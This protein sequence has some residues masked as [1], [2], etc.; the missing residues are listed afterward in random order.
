MDRNNAHALPR[1]VAVESNFAH[2]H[3]HPELGGVVGKVDGILLDLGVSSHQIDTADRGFT[4]S[5]LD[6]PLDMRMNPGLTLRA[7]DL[8]N[9][10]DTRELASMLRTYGDESRARA[11]AESIAKH[12]PLLTTGHLHE[13]V[14]AVTPAFHK[15]SR[16]KGLTATLA[17]VFQALRIV[18]NQEDVMLE[19]A[20]TEMAP[21]LLR[22]GGRLVVLSYHS[23]EDRATKR[24][25]RDGSTRMPPALRQRDAYGNPVVALP[26][27]SM[28]KAVK[29]S[30]EEVSINSRAR[31]A[32]LRVAERLWVLV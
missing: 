6:G 14:A 2:L 27:Q 19:S 1:F 28:G 11:L 10:L 12:R 7:C 16:R 31:S 20:L 21:T 32:T 4:F 22:P 15:E 23:L 18:V 9:E 17:R 3:S 25:M 5:Q 8:C 26:F 24:V 13:A 29:A 30:P